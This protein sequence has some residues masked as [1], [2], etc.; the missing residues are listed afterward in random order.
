MIIVLYLII[1][2]VVCGRFNH[3]H[4]LYIWDCSRASI[5]GRYDIRKMWVA[6]CVGAW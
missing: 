1:Y 2:L 3:I 4:S 5:V 6:N